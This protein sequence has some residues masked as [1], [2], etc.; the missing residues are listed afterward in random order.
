MPHLLH[1]PD[2][3]QLYQLMEVCCGRHLVKAG[4]MCQGFNRVRHKRDLR[5]H[6]RSSHQQ[7]R[8]QH[9]HTSLPTTC[10]ASFNSVERQTT[11]PLRSAANNLTSSNKDLSPDPKKAR[12]AAPTQTTKPRLRALPLAS[13]ACPCGI[14][15]PIPKNSSV[16]ARAQH[17]YRLRRSRR[18]A[19]SPKVASVSLTPKKPYLSSRARRRAS[20]TWRATVRPP[21]TSVIPRIGPGSTVRRGRRS[22]MAWG[23]AR[24]EVEGV[25]TLGG[26][27]STG[28]R[29]EGFKEKLLRRPAKVRK[30]FGMVDRRAC[31]SVPAKL[32]CEH[33]GYALHHLDCLKFVSFGK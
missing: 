6:A 14:A 23:G 27:F 16:S 30:V 32:R 33:G 21:R 18:Q 28:S 22:S 1:T 26:R 20:F 7:Q 8:Q 29:S 15:R 11:S 31:V 13:S 2:V 24:A 4:A 9:Q 3:Q 25:R 12:L 10:P 5:R 19:L 17:S